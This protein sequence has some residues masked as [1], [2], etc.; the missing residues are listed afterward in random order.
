MAEWFSGRVL[1]QSPGGLGGAANQL[2]KSASDHG[3][4]PIV[5]V[6]GIVILVALAVVV[7]RLKRD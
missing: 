4:M 2:S 7:Y 3:V 1:A 5:V 6:V